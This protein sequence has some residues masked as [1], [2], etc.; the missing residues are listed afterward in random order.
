MDS[1]LVS[2]VCRRGGVNAEADIVVCEHEER[3]G[4]RFAGSVYIILPYCFFSFAIVLPFSSLVFPSAN[5]CD[6]AAVVNRD[7][8][9]HR[10]SQ[11]YDK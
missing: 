1:C 3:L 6:H 5:N 4:W 11:V 2:Y 9:G 7:H 10:Y 8:P